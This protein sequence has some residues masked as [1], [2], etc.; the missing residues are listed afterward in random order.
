MSVGYHEP[1]PAGPAEVRAVF[2]G[3]MLALALAS[4]DQN[5]VGVALPRI[6][7]DLG[8]LSHLSW[9]V[10]AFLVT[11]TA[12]T[13][14]YGKLS[15]MYGRKP[16]FIVAI[17]IFL[18]GSSLCGLSHSMTELVVFRG[19]QGLG[20]GGLITLAQTT[21]AD[22][23]APR[24]RGRYQG[25]F[26]AV[27]ALSS[28]AGPL[29]GGFIT[30]V[31]SWRWIFYVNVPIGI[32]ALALIAFGFQ[33][34]HH[35]VVHRID[36]A[37]VTLL[38]SATVALLLVLSWGGV[39][40]PWS[41]PIIISMAASAAVLTALLIIVERRSS[42]PVLSP[43]IFHNRIVVIGTSVM[44]LTFMG[45]FGVAVFLPL[46]FQLVLGYPPTQAGLLMAPMTVGMIAASFIGGRMVS[47]SGRYKIFPVI[48]LAAAALSYIVVMV[49]ATMGTGI[50]VVEAA[51]I[52]LGIGFGLVMP[53]LVVAI[54]NA[55]G[56][57]EQGAAT[58]TAAYF[59][60][61]G[62]TFGVA[63]SGA[64]M[65]GQLR[66]LD[67]ERWAG[68]ARSGRTLLDQGLQDIALLPD[69]QRAIVIAAYRHAISTTFLVGAVITAFAF[70]LML[71]LPEKP[72]QMARPAT[73]G[74]EED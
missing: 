5:I 34:P 57:R 54:Q 8:G 3:L 2:A 42:E 39:Q 20:A 26:G 24:D 33:R 29:L 40:F 69:A 17:I 9:V 28:V 14:I 15:D 1:L 10:T 44:G 74:D 67:A 72:L 45:L 38:T 30:D 46:F 16:L 35:A 43:H 56:P 60:S 49:A 52:V 51:L 22:L 64:I 66:A 7:S 41:S 19:I 59:R 27:F 25:L 63:L 73:V 6:V 62:G 58:A 71:F 36:Y 65:T 70:L 68:M 32:V 12:T 18:I 13:P 23:V 50:G 37:A 53:N 55:V 4:L 61:L 31:L 21:I 11:S 48:G 47:R